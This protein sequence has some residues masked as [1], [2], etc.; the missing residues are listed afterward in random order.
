MHTSAGVRRR[1]R[2]QTI[3]NEN[4][5]VS[6]D[7]VDE[8]VLHAHG[9]ASYTSLLTLRGKVMREVLDGKQAIG[10]VAFNKHRYDTADGLQTH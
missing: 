6:S 9:G 7:A 5:R 10:C 8:T 1:A 3:G 4:R 2:A